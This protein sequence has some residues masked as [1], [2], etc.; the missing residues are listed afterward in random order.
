M[1]KKDFPVL[2]VLLVDDEE[3]W[4]HSFGMTLRSAGINNIIT[5]NDSA[6][7]MQ[8]LADTAVSVLVLDLN[9]PYFTG[10]ALLPELSKEFPEVPVIIITGL[11]QVETAVS[12]MKLGAYD[13]YTKVADESRLIAGVKR[14]V[15]LG[16]LRRERTSLKEHFLEDRLDHP[17]A[18]AHIIT[19][20]KQMRSIF[21]YIEAVASTGEPVLITGETG[22]GKELIARAIH[23][24][25]NCRGEFVAV[26]IA[27][28]DDTMFSDTLFGHKKGAFTGAE[29]TR[30]GLIARAEGGSLFL[31]EIGDLQPNAQSKLLRLIQEREY[32]ALGSDV[33]RSTSAR[34]IFATHHDLL[35]LQNSGSFRSDLFFRLRTHHV[36]IPPLH[37]RL[38]DLPPLL[39][40]FLE[41]GAEK[42]GKKKPAYPQ[43]LV[44]LLSTYP[45]PGNI[46]ELQ[47]MIFDCLSKHKSHTLSMHGFREYIRQRCAECVSK[48]EQQNN[49]ET[50]YSSLD[51]LP[52]LKD[53]C[54]FLVVEALQRAKG[55][56]TIAAQMLGIT[57]QALSWRLK[58][59]D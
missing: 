30:N 42:L 16:H 9:M 40:H 25:S 24:L 49:S 41:K 3:S 13:F 36:H 59:I 2:P 12:C 28:L 27:G 17:E 38:D 45:F 54:R 37:S 32:Y 8:L 23:N 53:S 21:Q 58:Q 47:S 10:D 43:E 29:D 35:S 48:A 26:N 20:N 11:D 6:K 34:M 50:I 31:D 7:V 39:D 4:L 46:R 5:C 15:E 18:F 56:Q 19:Q 55:N 44:T 22:V 1:S 14:A 51:T 33:S 57:R 52:T